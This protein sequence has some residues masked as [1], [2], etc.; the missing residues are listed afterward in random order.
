MDDE[1]RGVIMGLG[2]DL[3]PGSVLPFP[4]MTR[5]VPIEKAWRR[6]CAELINSAALTIGKGYRH[7]DLHGQ[8]ERAY[9]RECARHWL[10]GNRGIITFEEACA[11]V[12][13]DPDTSRR[14]IHTFIA[15]GPCPN[16]QKRRTSATS[17][18]TSKGH[19]HGE[20]F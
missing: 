19:W 11:A 10:A 15:R 17:S 12:D 7:A 4:S 5:H 13:C 3:P 2:L 16:V 18:V 8:E 1:S 9:A 20:E 14:L 6:L